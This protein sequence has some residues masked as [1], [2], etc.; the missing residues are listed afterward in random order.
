MDVKFVFPVRKASSWLGKLYFSSKV[1][2]F[3]DRFSNFGT[4][5]PIKKKPFHCELAVCAVFSICLMAF[6]CELTVCSHFDHRKHANLLRIAVCGRLGAT[7]PT[8]NHLRELVANSSV[9][10]TWQLFGRLGTTPCIG[11]IRQIDFYKTHNALEKAFYISN[12]PEKP[13]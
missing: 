7:F 8:W 9:R 13:S 5:A 2:P 1:D 11:C 12:Y 3:H 4:P 6:C 10:S